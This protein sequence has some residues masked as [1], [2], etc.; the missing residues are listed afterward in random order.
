MVIKSDFVYFIYT[1]NKQKFMSICKR[2]STE[3]NID[4]ISK[5]YI[6]KYPEK[7]SNFCTDCRK[8]KKCSNCDIEFHHKQNQTC[9]RKC[10][11]EMKAKSYL[12]SCGSVHNFCKESSSRMVWK[13]RLIENEGILNVFQRESVKEKSKK[14]IMLKY[15]V[16]HISRSETIKISKLNK[17]K[18][19]ML[20][21]PDFFKRKWWETHRVFMNNLGYDP[22]LH[23]FGKASKESLVV[24]S[25]VFK[26]CMGIGIS[27]EDIFFGYENKSEFFLK[28]GSN[29]FFYD[30]S[31]KSIKIIIEF[32]GVAFHAKNGEDDKWYN[33]F[34]NETA[35]ENIE[36]RRIKNNLAI[37]NGFDILEIW[38]DQ[39]V[40]KNIEYCKK[41]ILKKYENKIHKG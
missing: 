10:S 8:Y 36:K 25:E 19:K 23:I 9:S 40:Q 24:F 17:M 1:I 37:S 16:E 3:F 7:Y 6:Q 32:H 4:S 35:S 21:D 34:V 33:P 22:R 26:F 41:F 14:T 18:N 30:F 27:S 20:V 38:S 13:K 28:N 2:C 12:E 31:I 39:D 15:G 11:E 29:I 5:K